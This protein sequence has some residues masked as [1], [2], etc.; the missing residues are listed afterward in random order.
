MLMY[1][2]IVYGF[3]PEINGFVFVSRSSALKR[4]HKHI[5]LHTSAHARTHTVA[6]QALSHTS[7]RADTHTSARTDTHTRVFSLN[8]GGQF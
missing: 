1:V 8:I 4:S 6:R 2:P 7:A 5:L 3:L